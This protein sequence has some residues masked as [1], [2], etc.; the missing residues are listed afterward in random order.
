[1]RYLILFLIFNVH[2]VNYISCHDYPN[3]LNCIHPEKYLDLP[4]NDEW[5]RLIDDDLS[6]DDLL[7]DDLLDE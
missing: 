6:D 1:M 5:L 4:S 3:N 2:A 7:D